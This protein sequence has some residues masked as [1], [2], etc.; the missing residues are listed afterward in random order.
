MTVY[1]QFVKQSL[2][3]TKLYS[4]SHT[5]IIYKLKYKFRQ[6]FGDIF[7]IQMNAHSSP[8]VEYASDF[9]K[10]NNLFQMAAQ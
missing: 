6:G 4:M 10:S 7:G 1:V 8:F 9:K 5:E 3:T 2:I